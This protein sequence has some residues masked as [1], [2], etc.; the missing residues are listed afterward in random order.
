MSGDKRMYFIRNIHALKDEGVESHVAEYEVITDVHTVGAF[1]YGPY[2]FTLWEF[3]HKPGGEERKLCLRIREISPSSEDEPWKS[4]TKRGFHHGGGIAHELVVLACLFLRRRFK[5]GPMVRMNDSPRLLSHRGGWI[6]RPLITGASNL[7]EL[8]QWLTLAEQL[9]S[10]YHLRFVLSARLYHRAVQLIEE[11]PD[12]AYLN[13]VSAIEVLCQETD[14]GGIGLSDLD[15]ELAR[16]VHSVENEELRGNIER[17][18]LNRERFIRRRFVAFIIKHIEGTFWSE[19]ERPDHGRIETD[20][21]PDLLGRIYDQRSRT[22]HTGEPFPASILMPPPGGVEIDFA[23]SVI[24]GEK[25]WEAKDFI[26]YPHFF[27]RLVNHV[28]KT[29]LKRNQNA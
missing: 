18:I 14:I 3:S 4:A 29:F 1:D 5:L 10:N 27:E 25:K 9:N 8:P 12:M 22:L 2:Y 16:Y 19:V 17:C 24:A 23:L 26:P 28:L 7:A 13:L 11:Q 15:E 6:D 21:L 20:K